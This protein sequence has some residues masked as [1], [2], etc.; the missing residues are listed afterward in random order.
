MTGSYSSGRRTALALCGT[1]AHGAYHAGA[2]RALQEAGIRIDLVG[3]QGIGAGAA[4]LAAIDGAG[5]LWEAD[6]IW[7]SRDARRL[8]DWK[9]LWRMSGWIGA[10][11][12]CVLLIPLLVLFAAS[13]LVIVGFVLTLVGL[14]AGAA[15][16]DICSS[17]LRDAFA[18]DQLP[19]VVPRLA[20]AIVIV[21][22][23]VAG[24]GSL[25]ERWRAPARRRTASGWWWELGGAPLDATGARTAF[26]DAIWKLIRG[27]SVGR[28][29]STTLVGRR[30]AEVLAD[31]V[32]Q[33]GFRELVVVATDLDARRDVVVSLLSEPFRRDFHA[34]KPG[35]DRRAEAID[36]VGV[37]RDHGLDLMA[38]ALTPPVACDPCLVTFSVDGFWRGE[39]HRLCDR[40]A[41]SHRLLEE[42]AAAG[43]TQMIVVSAVAP[44]SQPHGL[45]APRLD[46]RNRLG[47]FLAAAECAALRDAIEAI[48]ERVAV[49]YLISPTHNPSGPFD[50]GSVYDEASD[51]RQGLD[52]L[53][54]RG[55]EDAYRQFI[56]PVVGASGE[57]L[58]RSADGDLRLGSRPLADAVRGREPD[59]MSPH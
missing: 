54:A 52:E 27:A 26:I 39:T 57:Q 15:L 3:G 30:Y 9:P 43:A 11:L 35:R 21:L 46:P 19:L 6:G 12:V 22:V 42:L 58:G 8:Y 33:P 56:E 41:A 55:Y 59:K 31:N 4:A 14:S 7:R 28:R 50:F 10:A 44:A 45:S 49:V 40:P 36:L 53:I 29:P 24:C 18:D 16:V 38:A 2:L 48:R 51:R 1:G 32:G 13:I 5:R 47:D 20:L 17:W 25:L 37:G 34:A 23:V